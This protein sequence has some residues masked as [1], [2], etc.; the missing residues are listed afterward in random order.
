MN[1][2][3]L[4]VKIGVDDQ[5][6]KKLDNLS[7]KLGG[8]LKTAAKIGAS[9]VGVAATGITALTTAAVNNYAEYEQLVGG[10][11]TL[12]KDASDK[13]KGYAEEAFKT[14]GM[15]AND[16]MQN[17]TAFSA[18]LINSLGGDTEKAADYAN[19]AMISMSDN[20]NKMGTSMESIVLTY[21]SLSRGNFAM[22]DNLKLG[23]G[24]T[25]KELERLIKDASTYTDVQ[26]E[27]G[28]AVDATSMSFDNIVNAIAVVQGKLGIAGATTQEAGTTIEGS[29]N[30]AKA[31]WDNL[32]TGIAN[33]NADFEKL[34]DD[35]VTTIVG[36]GTESN[37][38]VFGNILPR[39]EVALNGAVDLVEQLAPKIIE[40]LPELVTTLLPNVIDGAVSIIEALATALSENTDTLADSALTAVTTFA[41]A[42]IELLPTILQ[43][44]L[45]LLI[46]LARGVG[47]NLD[48]LIPTITSVIVEI[49]TILT[50]P[51]TQRQLLETGLFLLTELAYALMDA[52]PQLVGAV[53]MIVENIVIFLTDP[54]SIALLLSAALQIILAICTGLINALPELIATVP[55]LIAGIINTFAETDWSELG[56][57]IVDGILDGLSRAWGSLTS[58]FSSAW[59]KLTGNTD[60]DVNTVGKAIID[61]S[62]AGGLSY[63]PFDGY[64]A[65]LHKGERV[66]T[67]EENR[68]L[69]SD[70]GNQAQPVTIVVQLQSGLELARQVVADI[71]TLNRIEG[72]A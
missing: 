27:M 10:V 38:G 49:V 64:I 12:F 46:A 61:G 13:V 24:G 22:L 65:E 42:I 69:N 51:E 43:V 15:S 8:G 66:L 29:L 39:I 52:I 26:E 11:D 67:A 4:F 63:V 59:E 1:L 71:N 41:T 23:Y 30:S 72:L 53:N 68:A 3:E 33:D 18:T 14:A 32:V 2:F 6:S 21:Q 20:A 37:L 48:T 7:K 55:R 9:A 57:D 54:E 50:N 19:R 36:D 35:F 34:I 70:R 40:V 47:E 62:H 5:A 45:D 58:W 28:I 31:A 17:A 25:K 60:I 56:G 16:Y 44:G